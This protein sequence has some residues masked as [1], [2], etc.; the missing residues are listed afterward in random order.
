MNKSNTV[1]EKNRRLT[2]T[3]EARLLEE[4]NVTGHADLR[5]LRRYTHLHHADILN[6][7]EGGAAER[8][9]AVVFQKGEK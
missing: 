9:N 3:A 2:Q 7:F 6:K 4:A 8:R 1:T 5:S